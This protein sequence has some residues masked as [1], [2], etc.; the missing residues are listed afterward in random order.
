MDHQQHR[1]LTPPRKKT[2]EKT[3]RPK[4]RT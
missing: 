1:A 4:P 3:T 2:K